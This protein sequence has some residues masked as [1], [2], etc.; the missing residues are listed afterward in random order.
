MASVEIKSTID[1]TNIDAEATEA[2]KNAVVDVTTDLLA[3]ARGTAP[4]WQGDLERGIVDNYSFG[5]EMVGMI[6]VSAIGANGF[7]YGVLRHDH[8][9]NLGEQSTAKGSGSSPMFGGGFA[10][11]YEFVTR[12][13]EALQEDYLKYI[14]EEFYNALGGE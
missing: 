3:V 5:D 7:D 2:I 12:P 9:F 8:P 1:V 13:A 11:G 10:V 14:E 6:G 4:H